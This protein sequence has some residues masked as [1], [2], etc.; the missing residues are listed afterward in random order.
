[1]CSRK[2]ATPLFFSVSYLDPVSIHR[3][4]V[5]VGEPEFSVATRMPLFK[6]ETSVGG[7]MDGAGTEDK[8]RKPD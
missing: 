4:M 3:P 2:C 8:Q 1:M 6:T 5:A 7:K